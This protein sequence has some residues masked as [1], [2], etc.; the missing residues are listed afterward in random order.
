MAVGGQDL[1]MICYYNF[2]TAR[3]SQRLKKVLTV[4]NELENNFFYKSERKEN[5]KES[6]S[7][8]SSSSSS[9][10]LNRMAAV[11]VEAAGIVARADVVPILSTLRS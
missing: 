8:G 7:S 9:D 2:Y 5:I 3:A 4:N 10:Q 1:L 6:N 11:A